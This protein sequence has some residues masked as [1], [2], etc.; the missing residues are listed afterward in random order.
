[1][2]V[3][4][5]GDAGVDAGSMP[6]RCVAGPSRAA[7][8]GVMSDSS[9]G[10]VPAG[11]FTRRALLAA[12]VVG[13]AAVATGCTSSADD[14]ADAVTAAQVDR[15]ADQV[16]VQAALVAAYDLA[17]ASSPAVATE[18]SVL[19]AQARAQLERLQDAA[20]GPGASSAAGSAPAPTE[21]TVPADPA[22]ARAFLRAEVGRA[23]A[24]HGAACP[25]FTG[26]RAA[27]LG[28]IA[29]GLRGAEGQ[30]A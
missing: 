3:D 25:D 1:M 26:A 30:L 10:A 24:A 18:V 21:P 4:A 19:A 5:G 9:P 17:S 7:R 23:A 28:S 2:R 15:L 13:T 11:A 22:G 16:A 20:P 14:A 29:A 27:L 12:A 8:M 6:G